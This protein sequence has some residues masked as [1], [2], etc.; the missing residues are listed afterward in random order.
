MENKRM[1]YAQAVWEITELLRNAE[2][3]QEALTASLTNVAKTVE[4]EAGSIWF[5]NQKDQRSYPIFT[6]GTADLSGMSLSKGEG[7]AGNVIETGEADVVM[8]CANDDHF[9][10]R[11]DQ[12]VGFQTKSMICV[13]LRN[14]AGI[15]GCIQVIN[16]LDG[17]LFD[18]EDV[19]LCESLAVIAAIV[20]E[21]VGLLKDFSYYPPV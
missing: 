1:E 10:E 6:I 5:Y 14:R 9:S 4:A 16:K 17:T 13:P 3:I 20:I 8:D 2:T 12:Q 15:I 18:E 21:N 19:S 11:F 7:I